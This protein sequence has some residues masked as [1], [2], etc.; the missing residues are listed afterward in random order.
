MFKEWWCVIMAAAC[1]CVSAACAAGV[2]PYDEDWRDAARERTVPV[3]VFLPEEGRQ[4]CPV[5]L[6]SHGLGGSRAGFQY[7]GAAWSAAGYAVV[8][9]Q[10]PGSDGSLLEDLPKDGTT[11][12]KRAHLE[13]GVNAKTATDR[14]RDVRF[15]LDELQRR[16]AEDARLKG[17]LDLERV[18]IAGHSFGAF[19]TLAALGRFPYQADPRL[20]V[21]IAMSSQA[22]P[23]MA[24][25]R[26][27]QNV[28]TPILHMTGTKDVS[29]IRAETKVED[30][31]KAF[32]NIHGVD[33]FLVTFKDGDHMLFSGH[34]RAK[35]LSELEKK[36]QPL[37]QEVSLRFLD[38]YLKGGAGAKA[39]MR[40]SGGLLKDAAV[41]EMRLVTE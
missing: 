23:N 14:Y 5:M 11:A 8:V 16:N 26:L 22:A 39:E 33:Q 41:F 7:L 29:L 2:E 25:Q 3:R 35:G 4:P 12:A 24:A 28:K 19:T 9:M 13:A 6:L 1:M 18:G 37:I 30:R 17:R 15:V 34:P 27:F 21:G 36:Y 32:D 38:A 10:H 40:K 31:R 20:K